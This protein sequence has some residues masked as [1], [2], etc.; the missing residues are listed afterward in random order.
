MPI[1]KQNVPPS[2]KCMKGE[3]NYQE[4]TNADTRKKEPGKNGGTLI[5]RSFFCTKCADIVS[6]H[7]STWAPKAKTE[8]VE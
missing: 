8:E 2:E 5:F 1:M 3:H 6:R 7:V 4:V